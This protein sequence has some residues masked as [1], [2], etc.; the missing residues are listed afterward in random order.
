M[1]LTAGE[2]GLRKFSSPMLIFPKKSDAQGKILLIAP[3]KQKKPVFP[4]KAEGRAFKKIPLP[5]K[6]ASGAML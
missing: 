1:D 4:P 2:E 3:D 5:K 6:R